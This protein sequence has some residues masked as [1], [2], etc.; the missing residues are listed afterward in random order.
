[1]SNEYKNDDYAVRP[2]SR[3]AWRGAVRGRFKGLC[4]TCCLY[5]ALS[6]RGRVHAV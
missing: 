1:M 3:L 6:L 4:R 5:G 2:K